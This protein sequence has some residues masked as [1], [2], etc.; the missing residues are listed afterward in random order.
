[1]KE[2]IAPAS[3]EFHCW[4]APDRQAALQ[5]GNLLVQRYQGFLDSRSVV[6]LGCGEGAFLLSLLTQGFPSVVGV[7]SN[8]ELCDLARRNGVPIV[9]TDLLGFL[10][11]TELQ[12]ATFFYL[13]VIE[14]VP[15]EV[16]L[17]VLRSLPVGS[18]VIIQTPNTRSLRG[19]E[20]YFNV[21]SHVAAYSPWVIRQ[22]LDRNGYSV[23]AEGTMDGN[24][25]MNWKRSLR[26]FLIRKLFALDPEAILGGGNYFVV[27]DRASSGSR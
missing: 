15:Y 5:K 19:H 9:Q 13:D 17:E 25:P 23:V 14:H 27:A 1:M 2:Q 11:D 21:P 20:Y 7:D 18:R 24:H 4:Y 8:P 10:R 22:M 6:D 12:P 26:A 3:A 16:N